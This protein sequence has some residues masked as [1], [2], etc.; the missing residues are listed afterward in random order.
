MKCILSFLTF[1]WIPYLLFPAFGGRNDSLLHVLDK[2]VLNSQCY[3]EKKL[4]LIDSLKVELRR[5]SEE[6][7][8]SRYLLAEQLMDA[9]K[10][11]VYD[12]AFVYVGLMNKQ[13]ILSTNQDWIDKAKMEHCELLVS[14]GLF[15][16]AMENMKEVKVHALSN[17]NKIRY[18]SIYA[19]LYYDLS[20]SMLDNYYS[21]IY[22]EIGNAYQD[23]LISL[24]S[25]DSND[26]KIA[27]A[28]RTI[29]KTK[30][31]RDAI[32]MLSLVC[33]NI[34]SDQREFG[35]ATSTLAFLYNAVG[36]VE[37]QQTMLLKAAVSD[38]RNSVK[39][40]TAIL[41]LAQIL[42]KKGEIDRA[43][44]YIQQALQDARIY[45]ARHRMMKISS[46]LPL[47]ETERLIYEQEKR[48]TMGVCVI[49]ISIGCMLAIVFLFIIYK[50]LVHIRISR[51]LIQEMNVRL[52]KMNTD[53]REVS[54]I[55]DKYIINLLDVCLEHISKM[56]SM[57]SA[58][59]K[60]LKAGKIDELLRLLNLLDIEKERRNLCH[61]FDSVFLTLFPTFIEDF[62]RLFE[63]ENQFV[64][65]K[66]ELLNTELGIF[67]L[68]RLGIDD[69][70]YIAKFLNCSVNTIY[71]YRTKVRSKA[72]NQDKQSFEKS[73]MQIGVHL[74][75]E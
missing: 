14:G 24:L 55:K 10:Y 50:Q 39:E 58:F 54:K 18:Y 44:V 52:G 2:E 56:D 61:T 16:P 51:G 75:D 70:V 65:K 71:T 20:N 42:Y 38:I 15:P 26:Y 3:F 6:D 23:T 72:I 49:I 60:K 37:M 17:Q 59:R 22:K 41:Q 62:N 35:L 27:F 31:Y 46:I 19:R 43:H 40:T 69:P 11:S 73:I 30:K 36:D 33:T 47:I 64:P 29:Y 57:Q 48:K 67:S 21:S 5:T 66:N 8:K 1:L 34:S 68:F 25:E 32:Q 45:N 53:L 28:K 13:A 74:D 63:K 7:I 12:S 9:Y 4:S